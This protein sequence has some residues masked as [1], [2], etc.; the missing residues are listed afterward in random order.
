[1][2][3]IISIAEAQGHLFYE[4]ILQACAQHYPRFMA[5]DIAAH[6]KRKPHQLR[7]IISRYNQRIGEGKAAGHVDAGVAEKVVGGEGDVEHSH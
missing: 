7:M 6:F 5:V 1:M 3:V 4:E 2:D